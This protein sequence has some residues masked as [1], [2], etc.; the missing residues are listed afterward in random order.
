MNAETAHRA[1]TACSTVICVAPNGARRTH[2]DHPA[3]PIG[4]EELAATALSCVEAGATVLHLHVRDAEGRHSLDVGHYRE[5]MA[6]V[7]EATGERLLLQVTTEAVGRYRPHEQ[8]DMVRTLHPPCASVAVMELAPDAAAEGEAARFYAWARDHGVGL[9]HI[10]YSAEQARRLIDLETRGVVP[11]PQPNALFVLG[12][13][14][15]GQRSR[16]TDLLSFLAVW[17]PDWPWSVCA[18][19]PTEAQCMAAAIAFGGHVRVG[20]ENNLQRPDGGRAR[21]NAE[22][23]ANVAALAAHAGRPVATAAQARRLYGV[24]R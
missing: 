2:A 3:L 5:A 12:R 7:R 11:E 22:L 9:Q 6:A 1:D 4:P 10:V 24:S 19:G 13:Y 17:P 20:F 14:T 16:P 18:F 15:A 8:L 21:N 23:V